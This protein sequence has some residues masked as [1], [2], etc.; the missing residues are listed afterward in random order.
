MSEPT[1]TV[2]IDSREQSVL[3]VQGY[4]L[5]V[6]TLPAGDYGVRGF[7]DWSNP[8]FIVERK[9]LDDLVGSLTRDRDRF[10]RECEL[11]RRFQFAALIIEAWEGEVR[12][13]QYRSLAKPQSI[14]A[15]LAALQVRYGIHVVFAGDHEGAARTV[16]RLVRQFVRGIEKDAKRL[17]DCLAVPEIGPCA[18]T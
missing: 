4:P 7:S 10:M 1:P 14:L 2:Q 17:N 6:T 13:G 12:R 18:A 3:D 8:R 15:S 5:E 11:L 16:E 9:G